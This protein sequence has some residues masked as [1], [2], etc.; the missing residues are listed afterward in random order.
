MDALFAQPTQPALAPR[1]RAF[2]E[3]ALNEIRSG[4]GGD[5]N[6]LADKQAFSEFMDRV[7]ESVLLG[8]REP[9]SAESVLT[10]T[11]SCSQEGEKGSADQHIPPPGHDVSI[12][13]PALSLQ[14]SDVNIGSKAGPSTVVAPHLEVLSSKLKLDFSPRR[15]QRQHNCIANSGH[16][17]ERQRLPQTRPGAH[18]V[19]F[20]V[21]DDAFDEQGNLGA[22]VR[23]PE[24]LQ[25]QKHGPDHC[26]QLEE[27]AQLEEGL[28]LEQR[29]DA[30]H[31]AALSSGDL[32]GPSLLQVCA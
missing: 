11:Q 20:G 13:S 5:A 12:A 15:H 23:P 29:E 14:S 28:G 31:E 9:P 2:A 10:D 8:R 4:V 26:V 30:D 19:R 1:V 27:G 7:N 3:L 16:A 24:P 25:F 17:A 32:T 21:G 6:L 18:R 22:G